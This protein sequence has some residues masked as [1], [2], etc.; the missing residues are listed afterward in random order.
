MPTGQQPAGNVAGLVGAN[1]A[2]V[3]SVF[4]V[5]EKRLLVLCDRLAGYSAEASDIANRIHGMSPEVE[6]PVDVPARMGEVGALEDAI[7]HTVRQVDRLSDSLSRLTN[8]L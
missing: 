2:R 7:D 5:S 1:S 3:P 6:S 8:G 4:S